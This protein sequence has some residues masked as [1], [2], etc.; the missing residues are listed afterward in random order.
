M[1]I[2]GQPFFIVCSRW[3]RVM[4]KGFYEQGIVYS[5]NGSRTANSV[6][7]IFGLSG[8]IPYLGGPLGQPKV[9]ESCHYVQLSKIQGMKSIS[10]PRLPIE[11]YAFQGIMS[12]E[13]FRKE[14]LFL[15]RKSISP[16]ILTASPTL[17]LR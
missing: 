9:N 3:L 16:L 6:K 8:E 14:S 17:N 1:T 15:F 10:K 12:T 5:P 7:L 13:E 2:F 4:L 11:I